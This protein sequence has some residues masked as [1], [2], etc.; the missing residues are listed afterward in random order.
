MRPPE[1]LPKTTMKYDYDQYDAWMKRIAKRMDAFRAALV[2][3]DST[4]V[5]DVL[6]RRFHRVHAEGMF[7]MDVWRLVTCGSEP[8]EAV[9]AEAV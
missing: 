8:L 4:E 2:T 7:L 5:L 6:S 3:A 9:A 1:P